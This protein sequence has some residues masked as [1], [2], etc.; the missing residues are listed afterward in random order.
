MTPFAWP[1]TRQIGLKSF[2]H[3]VFSSLGA[4]FACCFSSPQSL[5]YDN[6]KKCG[7]LAPPMKLF[8]ESDSVMYLPKPYFSPS[9]LRMLQAGCFVTIILTSFLL[10]M[11]VAS[12]QLL[13]TQLVKRRRRQQDRCTKPAPRGGP[14][15]GR[16]DEPERNPG[17]AAGTTRPRSER[18][19]RAN[20]RRSRKCSR[21]NH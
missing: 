20:G 3:T 5:I 9:F 8:N 18:A 2:F 12:A 1:E 15:D 6:K 10:L 16:S 4:H 11:P 14:R 17:L 21:F 7:C 19:A 13:P